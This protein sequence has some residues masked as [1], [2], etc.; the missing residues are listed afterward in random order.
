MPRWKMFVGALA[1]LALAPL[2]GAAAQTNPLGTSYGSMDARGCHM[3]YRLA[4][5]ADG[6]LAITGSISCA[7]TAFPYF[8]QAAVMVLDNGQEVSADRLSGEP[9]CG[10]T[11]GARQVGCR[12]VAERGHVY[13]VS[14]DFYL[15]GA[16]YSSW[17]PY[18]N[19]P[20]NSG[21]CASNPFTSMEIDYLSCSA[22]LHH[23]AR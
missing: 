17:I 6:M 1:V 10:Y 23:V 14:F 21:T 7:A 3:A 9:G 16:G 13:S 11:M 15:E 20:L 19:D 8:T 2:H 5:T 22:V 18:P 12:L 4:P